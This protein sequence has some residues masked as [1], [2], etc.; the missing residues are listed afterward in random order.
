MARAIVGDVDILTDLM[1][2]WIGE[3]S[4]ESEIRGRQNGLDRCLGP[5]AVTSLAN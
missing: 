1:G 3:I 2:A 4:F 5:F